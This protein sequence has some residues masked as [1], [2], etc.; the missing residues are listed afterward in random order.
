MLA[1]LFAIVLVIIPAV[2][3]AAAATLTVWLT[4]QRLS[5]ALDVAS[6]YSYALIPLGCGVWLAHYGFHLLTG[7]TSFQ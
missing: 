7:V 4:G 3:M 2:L 5:S 6:R 1:A